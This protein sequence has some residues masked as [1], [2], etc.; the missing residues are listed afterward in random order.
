MNILFTE[1]SVYRLAV[2]LKILSSVSIFPISLGIF[3]YR[4]LSSSSVF[5][6]ISIMAY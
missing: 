1:A 3:F 6:E 4:D 2:D 5:H